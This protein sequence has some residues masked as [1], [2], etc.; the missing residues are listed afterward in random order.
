MIKDLFQQIKTK[1]VYGFFKDEL[2]G[3]IMKEFAALRAKTY[4]Y[5]TDDDDEK[6]K[7]RHKMRAFV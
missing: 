1:K 5:R 6:K 3:K 7:V 4:T 2:R